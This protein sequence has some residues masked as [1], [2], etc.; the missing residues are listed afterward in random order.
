VLHDLLAGSLNHL[1]LNLQGRRQS[2]CAKANMD[3]ALVLAGCVVPD[4]L[5]SISTLTGVPGLRTVRPLETS[6]ASWRFRARRTM[7]LQ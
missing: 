3:R 2:A 5:S 4:A 1:Y 6:V 7:K